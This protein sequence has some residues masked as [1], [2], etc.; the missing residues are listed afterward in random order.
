M[1]QITADLL[2]IGAMGEEQGKDYLS[3]VHPVGFDPEVLMAPR[4]I[5][6][7]ALSKDE[8][9]LMVPVQPILRFESLATK[10]GMSVLQVARGLQAIGALVDQVARETGFAAAEML[11][12]VEAE[13]DLC[14]RRGWYVMLYDPSGPTW[15]L[16]HKVRTTGLL[17]R[18]RVAR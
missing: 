1:K 18:G 15:L 5:M 17:D 4:T 7:R 2:P 14:I 13:K 12:C 11:T 6:A 16:R 10:P 8:P 3:W 9:V